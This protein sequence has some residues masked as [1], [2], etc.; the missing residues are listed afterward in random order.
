ME[1]VGQSRKRRGIFSVALWLI[2]II[3]SFALL[4]LFVNTFF[5]GSTGQDIVSLDWAGYVVASDLANP[6]PIISGVAG[7][8][9]VPQVNV[10]A[11]D[12]YSAAWIGIGGVFDNTVIQTGTQHDSIDGETVY[13]AWYELVPYEA[14]TIDTINVL[15]GDKIAASIYVVNSSANEWLIEIADVTK[16]QRFEGHFIYD[17]SRLS[18]EWIIERPTIGR[19]I[20]V[21]A[22]FGSVTFTNSNATLSAKVGKIN[23][24]PYSRAIMHN[25]QNKQLVGVSALSSDGSSFTVQYLNVSAST[26]A[27]ARQF[28][29]N[30]NTKR[31]DV[32]WFSL[33][34]RLRFLKCICHSFTSQDTYNLRSSF[35]SNHGN[36][37]CFFPSHNFICFK[38]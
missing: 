27:Q 16:E 10:S 20:G 17:S 32:R 18:A 1:Y 14:I 19:V 37:I 35:F 2:M 12:T 34:K 33:A 25:R 28:L 30:T 29:K 24:F 21:L 5:T 22:N 7:S 13:S 11:G 15:P 31:L 23:D 3:I 38:D 8:W 26:G 4:S 6:E 36:K 9:T